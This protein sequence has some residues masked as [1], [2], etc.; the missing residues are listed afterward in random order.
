MDTNINNYTYPELLDVLDLQTNFTIEELKKNATANIKHLKEEQNEELIE[1]IISACKKICS[2]KKVEPIQQI[3]QDII[4]ESNQATLLTPLE[5]SQ[6]YK[7]TDHAIIKHVSPETN[8]N[9]A[10]RHVEGTINHLRKQTTFQRIVFNTKFRKNYFTS[11]SNN[12]QIKLVNPLKNVISMHVCNAEIPNCIYNISTELKNNEFTIISYNTDVDPIEKVTK[13]IKIRDGKYSGL[14]LANYLNTFVFTESNELNHVACKFDEN[15]C[16]LFFFVDKRAVENGGAGS[17]TTMVF[18]LDFRNQSNLTQP[19]QLNLGWI[20][21]YRNP[22]YTYTENYVIEIHVSTKWHEG[23]NPE[24]TFN[25]LATNYILLSVNDFNKNYS[26]PISVPYQDG[27]MPNN[28]LIAII[29]NCDVDAAQ[30]CFSNNDD[31]DTLKRNYFG[32][33]NVDTLQIELFDDMGRHLD[34]NNSDYS[35]TLAVESLYD[36]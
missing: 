25:A 6:I 24:S 17:D 1:F 4:T 13:V 36:L 16:K 21:G 18:D 11:N 22:F 32:P 14:Q 33:V 29:Q 19:L 5:Q 31:I 9:Y 2:Q 15:V 3:I 28:G 20:L 30:I 8:N 27:T 10:P 7:T 35:F 34:L 23:Y 26:Q 12:Y